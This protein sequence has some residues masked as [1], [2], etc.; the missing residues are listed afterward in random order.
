MTGPLL[1][2]NTGWQCVSYC[3]ALLPIRAAISRNELSC[4]AVFLRINSPVTAPRSQG[5]ASPA[6]SS[7]LISIRFFLLL[8]STTYGLLANGESNI[9]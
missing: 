5:L 3:C 4:S 6:N 1:C 2:F 7:R 9:S 8:L